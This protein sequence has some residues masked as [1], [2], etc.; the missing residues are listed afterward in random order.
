MYRPL[1]RARVPM[2][3][4]VINCLTFAVETQ[5]EVRAPAIASVTFS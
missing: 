3:A 2:G 1:A 4:S 5:T